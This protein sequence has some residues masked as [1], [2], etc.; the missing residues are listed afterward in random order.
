[1]N[2]IRQSHPHT[3]DGFWDLLNVSMNMWH[4]DISIRGI[5]SVPTIQGSQMFPVT[6]FS[7]GVALNLVCVV[8]GLHHLVPLLG[9]RGLVPS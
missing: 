6:I 8:V 9:P 1:M 4:M 3:T 2:S 5:S 7:V